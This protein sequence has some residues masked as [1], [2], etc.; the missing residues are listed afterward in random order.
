MAKAQAVEPE[1]ERLVRWL[2]M[3]RNFQA[4]LALARSDVKSARI[5]LSQA[6]SLLQPTWKS[7]PN[8]NLRLV[9][10]YN[11]TLSGMTAHLESRPEAARVAWEQSRQLLLVDA[12]DEIPFERLDTLA[13]NLHHLGLTDQAQPHIER[14]QAAGYVPLQPW[15]WSTQNAFA[16]R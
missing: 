12:G 3:T 8:E 1:N 16:Q 2:A 5:H 6:A 11:L 10:A 14:L 7:T 9:L 4:R 13:R 15:P